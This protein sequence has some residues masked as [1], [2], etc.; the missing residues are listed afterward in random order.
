MK[1]WF[2]K[3]KSSTFSILPRPSVTARV[4]TT[5]VSPKTPNLRFGDSFGPI[6]CLRDGSIWRIKSQHFAKNGNLHFSTNRVKT[7]SR[8]PIFK[9]F[10]LPNT[11]N[12]PCMYARDDSDT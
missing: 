6:Y 3:D 1:M 2:G 10:G 7:N 4:F 12:I 8:T 5:W 11:E 9:H